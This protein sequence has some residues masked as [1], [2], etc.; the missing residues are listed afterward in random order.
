MQ[1]GQRQNMSG[2]L[3]VDG[4]DVQLPNRC[5]MIAEIAAKYAD[6]GQISFAMK[7]IDEAGHCFG[8]VSYS[9]SSYEMTPAFL[10]LDSPELN[11]R[12][13][14]G[15]H[16]LQETVQSVGAGTAYNRVLFDKWGGLVIEGQ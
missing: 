8:V 16:A 12:N 7:C 1:V 6:F 10:L 11:Y 2:I 4:D 9:K 15:N 3:I 5:S 14:L 13:R